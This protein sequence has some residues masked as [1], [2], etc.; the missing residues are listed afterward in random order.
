MVWQEPID[1][2]TYCSFCMV[3]RKGVDKKNRHKISY[4]SIPSVIRLVPYCEELPVPVFSG[5]S[6][7]ADSDDDQREHECYNDKMVSESEC[8]SDDMDRHQLPTGTP[9]TN[10]KFKIA[11]N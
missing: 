8:F 9:I 3:N 10:W 6:S 5:F 11:L 7:C 4:P 2:V 1:H